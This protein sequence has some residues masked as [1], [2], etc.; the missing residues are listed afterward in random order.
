MTMNGW[1]QIAVFAA[2]VAAIVVPLGGYMTKVFAGEATHL[3][4]RK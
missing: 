3:L 4:A 1:L 2:I